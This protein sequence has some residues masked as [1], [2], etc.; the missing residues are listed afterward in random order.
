MQ[1]P[2]QVEVTDITCIHTHEGC[3]Y[4]TVDIDLYARAVVG[5]SMNSTMATELVRYAMVMAVCRRR[6]KTAV[7]IHF[8]QGSQFGSNDLHRWCKDKQLVPSM[9]PLAVEQLRTES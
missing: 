1:H 4:L 3:L 8:D 6:L 2:D 7:M 9:S 5:L